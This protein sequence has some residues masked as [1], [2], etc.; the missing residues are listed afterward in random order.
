M[1]DS[2]S[3]FFFAGEASGDAHGAALIEALRRLRPDVRC[4]GAGGPRM[5]AAGQEQLY[6]LTEHAVV[7]LVEV[8]RH[9]PRLRGLFNQAVRAV[10][11]AQ[12]EAVVFIDY[13]GFNLR[14]AKAL[15]RAA[16]KTKLIFFISPQVWAWK[17]GRAKTMARLLDRLLVIFP[18]EKEWFAQHAPSLPVEWVGHPIWDRMLVQEREGDSGPVRRVALLPGSRQGE[19]RK[20]LPILLEAARHLYEKRRDLRFVWLAPDAKAQRLGLEILKDYP[21]GPPIE[22]YVGYPLSHMSRCGLALLASGT[23]SLECAC[24]G[25]PQ[26][27]FYKVHPLTYLIGRMVVKIPFVSMVN[28]LAG[29]EIIP[30]MIQAGLTPESLANRAENLLDDEGLRAA[31]RG[32]MAEAVAKLGPPGAGERAARSVLAEIGAAP[33]A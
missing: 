1:S 33:A 25:V 29:K 22:A 15:R 26:I 21:G 7:G 3:V 24:V 18:F 30:E 5:Q 12:P 23:V 4:L 16:P 13:P 32:Q 6:D 19:I 2:P 9:Y 31:M 28:I 11:K 14:L 10:K 8:L 20:H 17:S 27:V